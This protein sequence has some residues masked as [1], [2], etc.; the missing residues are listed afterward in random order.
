M[1]SKIYTVL[2]LILAIS[3]LAFSQKGDTNEVFSTEYGDFYG[4]LKT[5]EEQYVDSLDFKEFLFESQRAILKPLDPYTQLLN[6]AEAKDLEAMTNGCYGG[7]GFTMNLLDQDVRVIDLIEGMPA[8]RAGLKTGDR[9]LRID[10]NMINKDNYEKM[11]GQ[12]KGPAGTYVSLVIKRDGLR[13]SMDVKILRENLSV[14]TLGYYGFLPY[15]STAVYMKLTGFSSKSAFDLE[16]ALESLSKARH[17]DR[18]ILD[19]RGNPGGLLKSA[20]SISEKFL[21]KGSL[22]V[23]VQGRAGSQVF[24]SGKDGSAAD[25]R[26]A[27]LIDKQTASASE[28]LAGALQDNDRALI[29]GEKSFG[30]GLVQTI[31]SLPDSSALKMTT[32]KYYSPSGRCIQKAEYSSLRKNYKKQKADEFRTLNGRKVF[33]G[34]GITPDTALMTTSGIRILQDDKNSA[35]VFEFAALICNTG[36][37]RLTDDQLFERFN[38]FIDEKKISCDS[39]AEEKI[40]DLIKFADQDPAAKSLMPEL[41]ALKAKLYKNAV[42]EISSHKKEVV[43]ELRNAISLCPLTRWEKN[44]ARLSYDSLVRSADEILS[45]NRTYASLLGI[46]K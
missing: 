20:V 46:S 7:V 17:F 39:P 24:R 9:I 15:D 21:K 38:R 40:D 36:G 25:K 19:L 31:Y 3:S 41:S 35:L 27:V 28:I 34:G 18:I 26:M 33:S 1:R 45:D 5:L 12:I 22:I 13:D 11:N 10:G 29:C 8:V 37:Q 6:V 23:T 16:S 32:A 42:S 2:F 44:R 4:L 30:K 14:K 43:T